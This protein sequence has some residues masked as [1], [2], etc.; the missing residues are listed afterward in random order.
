MKEKLEEG[1]EKNNADSYL[2]QW[3]RLGLFSKMFSNNLYF[4]HTQD[5]S[6]NLV[7]RKNSKCIFDFYFPYETGNKL[8]FSRVE[9]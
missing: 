3:M 7:F 5:P 9:C 6:L 2:D 8:I 1:E 4:N